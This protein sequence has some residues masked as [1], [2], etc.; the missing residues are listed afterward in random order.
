VTIASTGTEVRGAVE[1][2]HQWIA[3][4]VLATRLELADGPDPGGRCVEVGDHEVYVRLA[5]DPRKLDPRG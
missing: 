4:E 2:H 5:L 1:A 3:G